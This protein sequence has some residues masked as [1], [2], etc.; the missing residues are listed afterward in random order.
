MNPADHYQLGRIA[1]QLELTVER[2]DKLVDFFQSLEERTAKTESQI[3]R[4]KGYL[5]AATAAFAAGLGAIW[6]QL[7]GALHL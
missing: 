7:S 1:G 2:L 3:N 6:H 5:A 4:M